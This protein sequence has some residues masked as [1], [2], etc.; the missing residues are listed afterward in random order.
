MRK[1]LPTVP[2]LAMFLVGRRL[3]QQAIG[4]GIGR[5]SREEV[6]SIGEED[7]RALSAFLGERASML[8]SFVLC[9]PFYTMYF[10]MYCIKG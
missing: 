8:S 6:M 4:H 7:L 1:A 2:Y 3:K 9:F 10:I 5:H